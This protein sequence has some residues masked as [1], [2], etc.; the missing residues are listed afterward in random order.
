MIRPGTWSI[1]RQGILAL[2]VKQKIFH[3]QLFS[4]ANLWR[5]RPGNI[6]SNRPFQFSVF[7]Q[8]NSLK[9][10]PLAPG[11]V[12]PCI[13]TY[14]APQMWA[15]WCL[16]LSCTTTSP[17]SLK[18][19]IEREIFKRKGAGCEKRRSE[20]LIS[21]GT[22]YVNER[23]GPDA[24]RWRWMKMFAYLCLLKTSCGKWLHLSARAP[25][26]VGSRDPVLSFRELGRWVGC[27]VVKGLISH[28]LN[29]N[30]A[31]PI[32]NPE[33]LIMGV[34]C[35]RPHQVF[36]QFLSRQEMSG[37]SNSIPYC[38]P[39]MYDL[40]ALMGFNCWKI[41]ALWQFCWWHSTVRVFFT[42]N[43]TWSL[44]WWPQKQL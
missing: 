27:G 7:F 5:I 6:L 29:P 16:G 42:G 41:Y 15:S 25:Y 20:I 40:S 19:R 36:D 24:R 21:W 17:W 13:Q 26:L 37:F 34:A 30:F 39:R 11:Q 23:T 33:N 44:T 1:C 8:Y 28:A 10:R 14:Q 32:Y 3:L 4:L 9:A 43:P 38:H 2:G 18:R 35:L 12:L 22:Y 31:L